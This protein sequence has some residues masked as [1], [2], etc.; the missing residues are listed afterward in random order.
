M[1]RLVF[2]LVAPLLILFF[3]AS[4]NGAPQHSVAR[5]GATFNPH[6][7]YSSTTDSCTACHQPLA[8]V[9]DPEQSCRE[10]HPVAQ[11]HKNEDCTTCHEPHGLTNNAAL[12][13]ENIYEA[14]VWFDG[15]DYETVPT[16]VCY[17]C[18]DTTRFHGSSATNS[19]YEN[20]D[21][22]KCH[23][24]TSGFSFNPVSCT[25]CHGKPPG[26]GAHDRHYDDD[27]DVSCTDCHQKVSRYQQAKHRNGQVTFADWERLSKTEVCNDCHG[28]ASGVA[29][30]KATWKED[31]PIT[32]C[33]GCH[34][35]PEPGYLH[36]KAA[37][38]VDKYW[39]VNGHGVGADQ[40]RDLDCQGC[41]N[42]NAPHFEDSYNP[43]LWSSPQ[44]LCVRCHNDP[45]RVGAD[46][47][48]HGNEGHDLSSQAKFAESC[49]TCHDPHGSGNL[50]A[51]QPVVRNNAVFFLSRSGDNSF[52]EPDDDNRD[53]LCATC[54]TSTAH[55]RNP[56][57]WRERPHYEGADCAQCHKHE[58]DGDPKTADAFMP[59]GGCLDCHGQ[60]QDNGDNV[61]PGGRPPVD[62]DFHKNTHHLQGEARDDQCV[63]CH[64]QS[65]HGDGYI[66]LRS[67]DGGANTRFI[68]ANQADLTNF[69]QDCHDDDGSTKAMV[70]GGSSS[71]PFRDNSNLFALAKTSTHSNEDYHNAIEGPFKETCNKCHAG[72]GSDNLSIIQAQINGNSIVFLSKTGKD[73]FDDPNKDDKNDLCATC[74]IGR[75]SL[76]PGGD[77]RPAGLPDL[78]GSD[79]TTCHLHDADQKLNTT[80]AFMPS[81][82]GCHGTPPPP[83][84]DNVYPLDENL[85][86]HQKHAGLESGQYA[87]ECGTCHEWRAP[88]YSG[89][90]TEPRSYQDVFFSN[91]NPGGSY[92][93]STRTCAGVGCHSN[94]D[95]S[96]DDLVMH[97]PNWNENSSLSC[98]GCHGDQY[99]LSTAAHDKHLLPI[100]RDRGG[101]AIGCF[102]CHAD[103]ARNNNND[104]IANTAYHVDFQKQVAM[105]LSD[106]W[107]IKGDG[108]FNSGD[109][110]CANSLC[111][112]DGAA[113]RE[114][115]G[116][117]SYTMSRWSDPLSGMCN[118]CHSI[119]P[120]DLTTGAHAKH[121]DSSNQGPGIT[122]CATCH[123]SYGTST[124]V[125]GKVEFKDGKTLSQTAVCN[126]CHSPGGA[127][128]GVAEARSKWLSDQ[129]LSC[130]G[131]HDAQPS[132]VKGVASPDI[133][134]DG[135][136]YGFNV[137]GHG[138]RGFSCSACHQKTPESIHFD[139]IA[140]TYDAEQD[141]YNR[142]RWLTFNG[143]NI[144][145]N[146]SEFYNS[147]NY[148]QC[149]M[150]H[151]EADQVG[152]AEGYSNALFT[153]SNPPP[154]GYPLS[155][156]E[157]ETRFRNER[158]EGF[159]FG[160]VPANVHWD[161]LDMNQINWD[162]D[163]DGSSDSKPSCATCHDPH[164]VKS[165]ANGVNHPAMTYADMAI[166][167]GQ[168]ENGAY[169]EVTSSD[170][171]ARCTTCH[172][173][174]GVRYYR[175]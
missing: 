13:Q 27:I 10:C 85:T 63:V 50:F 169:G 139:G 127:V 111:H 165:Y 40:D 98:S 39:E 3:L 97:T 72:H 45:S 46:V 160:N 138:S 77:H 8:A 4:G 151:Q 152:L 158:F 23:P 84:A 80:D 116:S 44:E 145:I 95:P 121:F 17:T 49:N 37:P 105:D 120:A 108:S 125:N 2:L 28:D 106:L 75:T 109:L 129:P 112:S 5:Q 42:P 154:A 149:Y 167:H 90:V 1:K 133:A 122:D 91:L 168:D 30:A 128:N 41:H 24:H 48:T 132:I 79:C 59:Q 100:Y 9:S 71:D 31:G 57:N 118:T 35:T 89:H 15:S 163:A 14:P 53:D 126:D 7:N 171:S 65:T 19:H 6:G 47:S 157:V 101:D 119:S 20:Q 81:C 38:A 88:G 29:E 115:P 136:N 66:D 36:G 134:G 146:E 61:P 74:H 34:N 107:G 25:V 131:C 147:G 76:H 155:V 11:T 21:C 175:P 62:Q 166:V 110:S 142:T 16:G 137:D 104:A 22:T 12:I 60:R 64:D 114:Q 32:D 78:R 143:L 150:C 148:A 135:S 102:E 123:S 141:N 18:H 159:N 68:L 164:G 73:S 70:P 130:E 113:S 43:R 99:N 92:N 52:D 103:T 69:C 173:S 51:A 172:P 87:M 156:P 33:T 140:N 162:S 93:R 26:S 124:H 174:V 55:N 117:P 144:P 82:N 67:A 170:Y 54:H 161:H 56:S 58:T 153:H 94:G 86:P 96:T 83:A